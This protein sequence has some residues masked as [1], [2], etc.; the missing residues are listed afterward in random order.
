M[1]GGGN[2]KYIDRNGE[3]GGEMNKDDVSYLKIIEIIF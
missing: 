1:E 3:G 2:N